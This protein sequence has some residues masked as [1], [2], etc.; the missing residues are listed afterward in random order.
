MRA[1]KMEAS[2]TSEQNLT[3]WRVY[4]PFC[5]NQLVSERQS[6]FFVIH[7]C[8]FSEAFNCVI[9]DMM[10]TN[11]AIGHSLHPVVLLHIQYTFFPATAPSLRLERTQSQ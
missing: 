4:F 8:Q 6:S 9:E 1:C 10:T 11:P 7:T 3:G 2:N 5:L